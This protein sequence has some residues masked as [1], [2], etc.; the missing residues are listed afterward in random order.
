M[1]NKFVTAKQPEIDALIAA[2]QQ[3]TLPKAFTGKRPSFLAAISNTP[4]IAVIAEYK[5]ASPSAGAINLI[6][7]PE[8]VATAYAKAGASALSILTEETY[9]MGSVDY[10]TRTTHVG[11]PLLRK[12]FLLHPLQIIQSAATPASAVLLIV[13]MLTDNTLSTMLT[14]CNQYNLD[15]VVEV[16]D[17]QDCQRAQQH[18]AKIIQ[19]NNRNLNT[20]A[21]DTNT[22]TK[23][24]QHKQQHEVWISAS[25][26]TKH[27]QVLTMQ[28][29]G[30]NAV[31]VGSFLM[32]QGTPQKALE[33][34]IKGEPHEG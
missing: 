29:C 7:Q 8:D 16:F 10:L 26:L 27:A 22:S 2:E 30:F 28:H 25:G 4:T 15:A 12:D 3:N 19:V 20:L 9:F 11:L 5:R 18:N 13:R 31:L 34:L 21:I 17:E 33:L 1:L 23:L 6:L 32:E 14:L 24:I